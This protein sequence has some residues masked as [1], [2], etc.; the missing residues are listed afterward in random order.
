MTERSGFSL[1]LKAARTQR[2]LNQEQLG[3]LLSLT[4]QA[5]AA[6]EQGRN[7]PNVSQLERLCQ[8][9][10]VDANYLVLGS[11]LGLSDEALRLARAFDSASDEGKDILRKVFATPASDAQVRNAY[12]LPPT[13]NGTK[14]K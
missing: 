8:K 9:L 2:K 11:S 12:G 6:W 4:K 3:E 13:R 5:V 1:R 10:E 14:P 7:Q